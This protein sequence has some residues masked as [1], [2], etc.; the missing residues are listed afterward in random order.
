[1]K[2]FKCLTAIIS[3]SAA[4][5]FS[6]KAFTITDLGTFSV[7]NENPSTILAAANADGVD[8]DSDLTVIDRFTST[9]TFTDTYGTFTIAQDTTATPQFQYTLTFTLNSGFVLAGVGMHGGGGKTEHFFSIDDQTTG[10]L[11]GPFFAELAGHSGTYGQLS[12]FDILLE[13][14]DSTHHVPDGGST[15]MLVGFAL[16]GL[17]FVRR[18]VNG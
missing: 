6:A 9:G 8:S 16:T 7:S 5:V 1:M 2:T 15:A 11:E 3:V 17:G 10:T 4:L 14:P 12:N 18:W 13:P